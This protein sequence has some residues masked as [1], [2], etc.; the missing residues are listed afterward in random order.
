MVPLRGD[1]G[2]VYTFI[3][4]H[5]TQSSAILSLD[6]K[7]AI[8]FM[9]GALQLII[10]LVAMLLSILSWTMTVTQ[11]Y[12]VTYGCFFSAGNERLVHRFPSY[13]KLT[14]VYMIVVHEEILRVNLSLGKALLFMIVHS[15][16]SQEIHPSVIFWSYKVS[17]LLT[18][19][20][21][22]L[23]FFHP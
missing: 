20:Y 14:V 23:G 9:I 8:L 5:I 22:R 7:I 11:I 15:R 21:S 19:K 16:S 6:G 10:L 13:I 2:Y 18:F 17:K 12:T 3:S 4:L 1:R